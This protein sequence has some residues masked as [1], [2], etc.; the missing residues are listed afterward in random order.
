MQKL[1]TLYDVVTKLIGPIRPVGETNTDDE[2][3][4]NLKVMTE[5]IDSLLTD[6]DRII[7]CKER[8]EY[9]MKRAGEFADKFF[10]EIGIDE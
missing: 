5:L 3:Y 6:V 4:E 9:S 10:H 7:S 1:I 8:N 2:R